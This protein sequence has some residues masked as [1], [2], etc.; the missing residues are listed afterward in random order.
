MKKILP[1][2][3]CFIGLSLFMMIGITQ[4]AHSVP[5]VYTAILDGP[6]EDP[7]NASPGT[8][9]AL[10]VIDVE[11][12]TLNVQATFIDLIGTTTAAH[13]HAPTANPLSGNAGVATMVPS[14]LGFPLGVTSGTMD[15]FYDTTLA[16]T[17]NPTF[18]TSNGGTVETAE[19]ALAAYLAEGRAY[20]NIH[21]TSFPAGEIRGFLQPVPEPATMLLLGSGLLGLVG[22]GRR[23]FSKK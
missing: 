3:T 14:F 2:L 18:I 11:A 23:K 5:I 15:I 16:S 20:F 7:P 8:G 13:I 9:T 12:H 4:N 22:Y 1:F 19:A 10:V 6:S 21:T 17:F